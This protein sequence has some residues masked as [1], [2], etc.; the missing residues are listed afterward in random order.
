M[1]EPK[2]YTVDDANA[3]LPHVA[4]ALVE[5]REKY[6]EAVKIR[7]RVAQLASVNGHSLER[8]D[9]NRTLALVAALFERIEEW[10]IELRDISTGLIDFPTVIEG[11]EAFLCWRLGEPQVAYWHPPDTGLA[12][13]QPL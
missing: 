7:A 4:P 9:W 2:I 10:Q 8:D 13:R 6:E 11:E 3:L 1:P 5:L 12:G